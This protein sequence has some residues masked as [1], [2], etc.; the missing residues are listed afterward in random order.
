MAFLPFFIV[1]S[2]ASLMSLLALHFTQYPSIIKKYFS[3]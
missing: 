2:A 1:T 3:C